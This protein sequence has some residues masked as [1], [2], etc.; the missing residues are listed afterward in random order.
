METIVPEEQAASD[1][2]ADLSNLRLSQD[3]AST[4]GVK[5]ALL[6]V[7]VRKPGR[8]QF[9]RVHPNEAYRLDTAVLEL[10]DTRETYLVDRSL[11]S[12][13]PGEVIAKTIY[14]AIDRQGNAFL[15]PIR[16]PG[17]DGRLDEWN[18][19]AHEAAE[20]AL[21]RWVRVAANMGLGAYDVY[22]ATGELPD[23]E[24]PEQPFEQLLRIA[25]KNAFIDRPDHPVIRQLR[26]E[27]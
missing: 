13:L 27:L 16:L 17:E 25:F 14:T 24:W 9:V 12:E 8:Q 10:K 2:F 3:F 11:W 20:M 22:E 7:P 5:K 15:W 18:R 6:T 23:P 4:V 19:S 1:P 26:G 21:T